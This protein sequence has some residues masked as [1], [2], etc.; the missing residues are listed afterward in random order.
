MEA[1]GYGACVLVLRMRIGMAQAYW[2]GACVLEC[3][4][5]IGMAQAYW[6]G[7]CVLVWRMRI[8]MAHAYWC[9]ECVMVKHMSNFNYVL[10]SLL[11]K[12]KTL[13]QMQAPAWNYR[14]VNYLMRH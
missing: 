6:Y 2:Y 10:L 4:M 7:A 3:R 9:G 11:K 1:K 8:G 13:L 12:P 14:S 5:R